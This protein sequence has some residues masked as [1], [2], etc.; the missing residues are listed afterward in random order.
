M[1]VLQGNFDHMTQGKDKPSGRVAKMVVDI[2]AS[3]LSGD[4]RNLVICSTK[5][6]ISHLMMLI[7]KRLSIAKETYRVEP[8][9][10]LI[11]ADTY[12][13]SISFTLLEDFH[14]FVGDSPT[15]TRYV[16]HKTKE[17]IIQEGLDDIKKKL[18]EL[19]D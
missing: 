7:C 6:Q 17:A 10:I 15:P 11:H 9:C 14:I 8:L 18:K 5:K 19:E 3:A 16:H 1:D 4:R 2:T 12:F 13:V